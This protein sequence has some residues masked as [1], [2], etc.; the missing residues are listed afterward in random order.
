MVVNQENL[1]R[2]PPSPGKFKFQ[3]VARE[4]SQTGNAA[5]APL[6]LTVVLKDVNDN[7][8]NLPMIPPITVEAGEGKREVVK[9]SYIQ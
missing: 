1:D 4:K 6:A 7:A 5:S 8:P 2:D 3:V 9:V